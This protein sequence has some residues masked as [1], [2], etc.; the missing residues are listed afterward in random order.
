MALSLSLTACNDLERT[1]YRTLAT[2]QAEYETL[3][4]HMVEA[5]L[6]GLLT[7]EQWDRF[8][9][10]GHRFIHAHNSAVD[11]FALWSQTKSKNDAARLAAMLEML[12][13]LIREINELVQNFEQPSPTPS[14]PQPE[15]ENP[16]PT[17]ASFGK[18]RTSSWRLTWR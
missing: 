16:S 9:V 1:A 4:Q 5:A 8:A 10:A 7:E 15:K 12:P 14:S 17:S 3:Q 13:R 6:Q 2:T 11:A 18:L